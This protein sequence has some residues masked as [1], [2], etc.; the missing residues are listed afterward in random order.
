LQNVDLKRNF[1]IWHDCKW[2]TVLGED[3][4]GGRGGLWGEYF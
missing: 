4:G 2:R 3:Q 1:T